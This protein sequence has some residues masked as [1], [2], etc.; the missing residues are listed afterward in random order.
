LAPGDGIPPPLSA[1]NAKSEYLGK[2]SISEYYVGL[3]GNKDRVNDVKREVVNVGGG[4]G[5]DGGNGGASSE[6]TW[7]PIKE[8][9]DLYRLRR[10]QILN[11][12]T[13][14]GFPACELINL[15]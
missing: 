8:F 14:K 11:R 2:D 3:S 15:T 5:G 13:F 7:R 12:Q 10:T 1:S 9:G 4:G 6:Q